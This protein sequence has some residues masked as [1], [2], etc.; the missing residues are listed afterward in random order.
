MI[1]IG[2][3]VYC[4]EQPATTTAPN[5]TSEVAS[6]EQNPETSN[7]PDATITEEQAQAEGEN[8]EEN[9]EAIYE[10]T[11][12]RVV[13]IKEN[14]EDETG[15]GKRQVQVVE[16]EIIRGDYIGEEFSIEYVS[17][18][19]GV[20]QIKSRELEVGNKVQV[21]IT[22]GQDGKKSVVIQDVVKT[23]SVNYLLIILFLAMIVF[24]GKKCINKLVLIVYT[25]VIVYFVLIKR[26]Y[27]G[28]NIV[29]TSYLTSLLLIIGG[30]LLLHGFGKK[31]ISGIVGS[32]ASVL[33]AGLLITIFAK[34]GN[35]AGMIEEAMQFNIGMSLIKYDFYSLVFAACILAMTG[36][37]LSISNSVIVRL[38]E[39]KKKDLDTNWKELFIE[40]IECG[41]EEIG[42]KIIS[43]MIVYISFS[44]APILLFMTNYNNILD[45][46]NKEMIAENLIIGLVILIGIIVAEVL[47]IS[48]YSL[49]NRDKTIYNKSSKNRLEG[50]RSLKL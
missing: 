37:T 5:S 49:I 8:V 28:D 4:S 19:D 24:F 27:S 7:V 25:I 45:V 39:K 17:S 26:I 32:V 41:R 1:I 31:T 15:I 16:V 48:S 23:Q 10:N 21:Q 18:Y 3:D 12:G 30:N 36:V 40:G 11:V 42:S 22:E 2:C 50:K 46:L 38:E 20:E 13:A 34:I 6:T 9:I 44:L 35:L 33:M 47:M 43:L 14:K 29:I